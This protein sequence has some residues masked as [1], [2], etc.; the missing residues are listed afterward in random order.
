MKNIAK[1]VL[2]LGAAL[3]VM[4]GTALP[5]AAA[6][7][8]EL[9]VIGGT[10]T[11]T[12]SGNTATVTVTPYVGYQFAG[13][14][15]GGWLGGSTRVRNEL[16]ANISVAANGIVTSSFDTRGYNVHVHALFTRVVPVPEVIVVPG[17]TI[18]LEP[19]VITL[20]PAEVVAVAP[21]APAPAPAAPA[22]IVPAPPAELVEVPDAD[23]EVEVPELPITGGADDAPE[24]PI[25]GAGDNDAPA[26]AITGYDH[27]EPLSP[28]S[29][30]VRVWLGLFAAMLVAGGAIGINHLRKS[31]NVA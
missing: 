20:P 19:E 2:A 31:Q 27:S 7:T 30:V 17:E 18:Y 4:F 28:V 21:A 29:N 14:E 24:L 5:A 8:V 10:G 15:A 22:P 1:F 26:L 12:V 11:H 16:A 9:T 3:A 6:P 13:A 25:T 23:E